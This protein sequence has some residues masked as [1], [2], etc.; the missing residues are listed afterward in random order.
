M[1]K[2]QHIN[3]KYKDNITHGKLQSSEEKAHM[4][5]KLKEHKSRTTPSTK[6]K[7]TTETKDMKTMEGKTVPTATMLP[8]NIA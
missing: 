6:G 1:A 3:L 7:F 4:E 2:V 5:I 8:P